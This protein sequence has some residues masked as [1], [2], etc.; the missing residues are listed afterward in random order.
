MKRY[1]SLLLV[2]ALVSA[3]LLAS[4]GCATQKGPAERAGEQ[5]DRAVEDVQDA[6]DPP[7]PAE[8]AG[9]NL[10]RAMDNLED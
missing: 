2:T 6:I 3:S 1:V 10:D 8:K 9:R 7:G 5:V 4:S